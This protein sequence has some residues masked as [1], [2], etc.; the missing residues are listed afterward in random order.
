M[1]DEYFTTNQ[2]SPSVWV[3]WPTT[4]RLMI[5]IDI[6]QPFSNRF[7]A[8]VNAKCEIENVLEHIAHNQYA[9]I[10]RKLT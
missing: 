3:K 4:K 6:H 5:S 10:L 8:N 9:F 2:L 1:T 7:D